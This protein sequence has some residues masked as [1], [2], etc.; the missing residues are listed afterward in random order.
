MSLNALLKP[1]LPNLPLIRGED[2]VDVLQELPVETLYL[3]LKEADPETAL[4]LLENAQPNQ[5]QGIIDLDCWEGSDFKA[6]RALLLFRNLA[7]L[8]PQK[9]F[10]YMKELD[11][12][13][14][15]RSLMEL[16]DVL[17]FDPQNPPDT[18]EDLMIL[19]PDNK[20]ALILKEP[21]PEQREAL[22]QWLNK[23]SACSLDLMRRHLESCKWE[24]KTDLEEFAYQIKKGRLEDMGFVDYHEAI[25]LYSV[26]RA[27]D[28]KERLLAAPL[29]RSQKLSLRSTEEEEMPDAADLENWLPKPIRRAILGAGFLADCLALI[30][31]QTLK[32]ILLQEILR[33]VNTALSADRVLHQDLESIRLSSE[34]ARR[35]IDLGLA[36][37][38]DGNKERG[39]LLL[40]QQAI[41]DIHRLGW[42]CLQD[43]AAGA[44]ALQQK[45]GLDFFPESDSR[46]L[47][48]LSGRHP[49]LEAR[50][51]KDIGAKGTS[52][53]DLS[54]LVSAGLRLT[55]LASL[56]KFFMEDLGKTLAWETAPRRMG[57][58][59]LAR[60]MTGLL[61]QST[62]SNAGAPFNIK[63][64]SES[65]WIE[66]A[67]SFDETLLLKAVQLVV[68]RAP[69]NIRDLLHSR[70]T[71]S[72]EDLRYLIKNS[73]QKRPDK[74]Y[75]RSI[76]LE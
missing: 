39:A 40:E 68:E 75:A 8:E 25:Q 74:R 62:P 21:D 47:A 51:L 38:S 29:E 76:S 72:L 43:L 18:G 69:E 12:E 45:V 1:V 56:Q 26:G 32:E 31:S 54:S 42:L 50:I 7:L 5:V 70:V 64:L 30:E 48:A 60:L 61:R 6:E 23:I 65:E 16:V 35:Y 55:K 63:P 17:D 57:E 53:A 46:F 28:T 33:S 71:E 20:Y 19:S 10:D 24:Q 67:R 4:W 15:V 37:L 9:L 73:P 52:I 3:A 41:D 11:P 58:S 59:A 44:K 27:N 36:Y 14:V 22:Y 49:E 34:R 66:L 2:E 13:F